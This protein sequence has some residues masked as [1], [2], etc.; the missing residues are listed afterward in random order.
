VYEPALFL[1]SQVE[2]GIFLKTQRLARIATASPKK[3]ISEVSA[4]VLSLTASTSG[5]EKIR[6]IMV[7]LLRVFLLDKIYVGEKKA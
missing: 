6:H 1:L 3:S 2:I 4:V 5:W 7:P